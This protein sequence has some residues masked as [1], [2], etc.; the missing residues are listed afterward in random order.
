MKRYFFHYLQ[1]E[2]FLAG[3]YAPLKVDPETANKC[4]ALLSDSF[5]FESAANR[6]L[7]EWPIATAVNLS[8]ISINR[9]AWLGQAA[10]CLI[11]GAS[12]HITKQ[13]WHSMSEHDQQKANSVADIV[14]SKWEITESRSCQKDHLELTF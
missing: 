13:G 9:Q 7:N 8:N 4:A 12:E 10:C 3:Q 2:D 14:I 1:W 6:I 5:R 11:L